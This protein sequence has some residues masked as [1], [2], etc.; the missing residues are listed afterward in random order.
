MSLGEINI[1]TP[2]GHAIMS[3]VQQDPEIEKV[4]DI[5]SYTGLGTTLC[6]IMGAMARPIYKPVSILSLETNAK[7]LEASQKNWETRPGKEMVQFCRA[8]VAKSMM[9]YEE[10]KAHPVFDQWM[11]HFDQWHRSDIT[12]FIES[13]FIEINS[14]VDLVIIDGGEY[15][16][17]QD[18][19]A[20]KAC[21]PKYIMLDDINTMKTDRVLED[22]LQSGYSLIYRTEDRN[23]FAILKRST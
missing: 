21:N 10:I 17:F 23:G 9:T 12:N 15:C 19:M 16:G 14:K 7:H 1:Y 3:I 13:P 8:R 11:V 6:V 18:Y 20:I 4:L 22:A 2:A 5:G